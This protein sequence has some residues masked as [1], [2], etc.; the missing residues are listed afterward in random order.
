VGPGRR[1]LVL[2]DEVRSSASRAA[3]HRAVGH[4]DISSVQCVHLTCFHGVIDGAGVGTLS[5]IGR[6]SR[7][8]RIGVAA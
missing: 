7:T 6:R 4:Y 3:D 5:T 8:G 1:D 2:M